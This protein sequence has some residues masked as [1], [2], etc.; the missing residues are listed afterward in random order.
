M[1]VGDFFP[2]EMHSNLSLVLQHLLLYFI[3]IYISQVVKKMLRNDP[4][5]LREEKR[6]KFTTLKQRGHGK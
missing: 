1:R 6:E 2:R 3:I 4:R 5:L